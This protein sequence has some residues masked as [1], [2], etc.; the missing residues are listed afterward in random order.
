MREEN[1]K[2]IIKFIQELVL[3]SSQNEID[4]EKE[5][6]KFI[7][8]KLKNFGFSPK[9][10]GPKEHPSVICFLK[11]PGAKKIIW[12]ESHLDTV[13]AGDL[14]KWKFPPFKGVIKGNKMYGRGVADSKIGMAIFSYLAKDLFQNPEFKGNIFLSFSADEESGNFTGIKE[15]LKIA[16]KAD[17]CIL[18]YQ[19]REI[20]IGARGWLRLKLI[21]LGK[22]A[23]TGARY[24]KGINAIHKMQKAIE[25]ILKLNFLKKKEKFFEYGPSL[26]ISLIKGGL[27]MNIVP[28]KCEAI[29]DTRFLP[30]QK[31]KLIMKEIVESL[32]K[33]KKGDKNF[34]FKIEILQSENAFLTDHHHLFIKILQK[35]AEEILKRRIS[36][37]TEGKGS[38]GNII[39]K[40]NTP[41][42]NSLGV[43]CGSVHAP[44]EW[45]NLSDIP[46]VFK[47]YREALI[48][49]TK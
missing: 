23:H 20:S 22:Q 1:I 46:K 40:K 8:G 19:G 5:I 42:V 44:N 17:I 11:K 31:P 41:I 10:I 4:G 33:I 7:F 32:R 43:R 18:G 45:I 12:L 15:I 35:K 47:I 49:F 29:I 36:L 14:L 24:S 2:K 34:K 48:D 16:P 28:D 30:S 13:P 9:I 3:I 38:V 25:V 26:N 37:V 21:T 6:S 39:V 27:F